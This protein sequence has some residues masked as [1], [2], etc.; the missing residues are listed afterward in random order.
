MAKG[1]AA[2]RRA[3]GERFGQRLVRRY[4]RAEFRGGERVAPT[5][6]EGPRSGTTLNGYRAAS[7]AS[8]R[9]TRWFWSFVL[10]CCLV[11]LFSVGLVFATG[12]V[13]LG[14]FAVLLAAFGL[15]LLVFAARL[16]AGVRC[17]FRHR[18]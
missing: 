3:A 13:P 5:P 10:F 1:E 14:G 15:L 9:L 16:Q 4:L 2:P 6:A 11:A 17:M 18:R 7:R 12:R 8:R